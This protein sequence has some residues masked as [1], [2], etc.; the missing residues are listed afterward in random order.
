[1][2]YCITILIIVISVLSGRSQTKWE[3]FTEI[4]EHE[5]YIFK[6]LIDEKYPIKMYLTQSGFCGEGNNNRFKA[7]QLK[8]WYYYESQKK[9]LPIIGSMKYDNTDYFI[10]LFVPQDY[11]DTL[12]SQTC[13]LENYSEVFFSNNC[14]TIEDFEWK[15]HNSNQSFPVTIE[16]EHDFS[17]G[18]EVYIGVELRGMK[19]G[20]INLPEFDGYKFW[21]I[22]VLASKEINNEFYAIIDFH[23]YSNPASGGSGYCGSGV[24][25]FR[26]YF[27]I[28]YSFEI[29][30]KEIIQ[31]HSC[32]KNI[33][34]EVEF[35]PDFPEKGITVKK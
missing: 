17:Y 15:M 24:E 20:K 26:G 30:K 9:K 11:L 1:M 29:E 27:H 33:F 35:D 5:Y 4:I 12:N 25:A 6:G 2:K 8:G 10:K 21:E 7:K 23:A 19:M 28:N 32:Y 3:V 13:S 31:F 34:R 22:K 16:I 18:S 14:C